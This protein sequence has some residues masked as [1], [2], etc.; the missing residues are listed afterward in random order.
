MR[1]SSVIT[2]ILM[3]TDT[4]TQSQDGAPIKRKRGFVR[5]D[6]M[7]F[8][9][10]MSGRERWMTPEQ[11][12]EMQ[13]RCREKYLRKA[14][15]IK[16]K[17][18]ARY[19]ADPE[20][21][22][23]KSRYYGVIRKDAIAKHH[24]EYAAKHKEKLKAYR[25]AY[26]RENKEAID[27]KNKEY[28]KANP[29][30]RRKALLNY[31]RNISD[32]TRFGYRVRN[33]IK[34][35]FRSRGFRKASKSASILGCDVE[36]FRGWIASQFLPGMSF[37]NHGDWHIDHYIPVSFAKSEK[38]VIILNHYSNLRP[39]WGSDNLKK[40]DAL[41]EDFIDRWAELCKRVGQEP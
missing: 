38:D 41:P 14:D 36:W 10:I 12:A 34:E 39:L 22:R 31:E 35:S 21:Y 11:F 23:A 2:P 15:E 1:A 25:R 27:A 6:G 40:K 33:L 9:A 32:L 3:T 28:T 37:E 5:E 7:I 13:A 29:E 20:K 26:Y 30:V 8:W 4:S 18:K 16:A 17:M 24:K 19:D